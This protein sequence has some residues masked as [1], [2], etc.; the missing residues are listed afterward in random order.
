LLQAAGHSKRS[1]ATAF[2]DDP[3]PTAKR[4]AAGDPS[5][6]SDPTATDTE[7][8]KPNTA[9]SAADDN[10]AASG[11]QEDGEA[12]DEVDP[13][14]K[15]VMME[16]IHSA[17]GVLNRATRSMSDSR[18]V[19]VRLGDLKAERVTS[20]LREALQNLMHDSSNL[21]TT[22]EKVGGEQAVLEKTYS[23][24]ADPNGAV[25]ALAD[26]V[27][28]ASTTIDDMEKYIHRFYRRAWALT[29]LYKAA[30]SQPTYEDAIPPPK[31]PM[32]PDP[33]PNDQD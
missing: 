23:H 16:A 7:E 11:N 32:L 18:M 21:R 3:S 27:E 30:A 15:D 19:H 12:D 5:G 2:Q 33:N 26:D 1:I 24:H 14:G 17:E 6:G 4:A 31:D 22:L 25:R 10:D 20:S 8:G 9:I 28:K 13:E 29:D